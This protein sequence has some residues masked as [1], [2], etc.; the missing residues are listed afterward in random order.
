[1]RLFAMFLV[2]PWLP[3]SPSPILQPLDPSLAY[4]CLLLHKRGVPVN[5]NMLGMLTALLT[6][7]LNMQVDVCHAIVCMCVNV[8][9]I[10]AS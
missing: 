1:M 6:A 10:C 8:C 3:W 5:N 2:F 4:C 9:I 7:T